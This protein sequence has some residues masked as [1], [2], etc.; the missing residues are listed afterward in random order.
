MSIVAGAPLNFAT[1]VVINGK[2]VIVHGLHT[3]TPRKTK[4]SR[5]TR[6]FPQGLRRRMQ[7]LVGS[8]DEESKGSGNVGNKRSEGIERPRLLKTR[9]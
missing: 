8:D 5:R 9:L 6:L 2:V 1:A 3:L 4:T 7:K